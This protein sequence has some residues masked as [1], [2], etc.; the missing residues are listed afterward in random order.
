MIETKERKKRANEPVNPEIAMM[1]EK[2]LRYR[3]GTNA[4]P[5]IVRQTKA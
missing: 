5:S 4:P 1:L 2:L 3:Q